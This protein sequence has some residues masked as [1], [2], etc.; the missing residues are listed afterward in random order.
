MPPT[1]LLSHLR[2]L[3]LTLTY[4]LSLCDNLTSGSCTD[5]QPLCFAC[6]VLCCI[7]LHR[8][9]LDHFRRTQISRLEAL[10]VLALAPDTW[11]D[12][13]NRRRLSLTHGGFGGGLSR[14]GSP[15]RPGSS[16]GT[17][18]FHGAGDI[19]GQNDTLNERHNHH[20]QQQPSSSSSAAGGM[21]SSEKDHIPSPYPKVKAP[22]IDT[23]IS[24]VQPTGQSITQ[25]QPTGQSINL[26][27]RHLAYCTLKGSDKKDSFCTP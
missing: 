9:Q 6:V 27:I 12:D 10:G 20:Q 5:T 1:F 2:R 23:R 24:Q 26:F 22:P 14:S 13:G 19:G 16:L 4:P 7:V 21:G 15:F 17:I 8:K 11:L 18:T 3:T 25:V